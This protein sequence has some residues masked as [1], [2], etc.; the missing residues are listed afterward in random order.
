M[1]S[2]LPRGVIKRGI[3][4]WGKFNGISGEVIEAN[5]PSYTSS[6]NILAI[7]A[8][9]NWIDQHRIAVTVVYLDAISL[10]LDLTFEYHI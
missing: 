8:S 1:A 2:S 7:S 9:Y 4:H 6:E 5:R 3:I 10:A